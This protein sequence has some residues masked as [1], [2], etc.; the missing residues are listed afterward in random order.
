MM[1]SALINSSIQY[2][3][4]KLLNYSTP[5][6]ADTMCVK[7]LSAFFYCYLYIKLTYLIQMVPGLTY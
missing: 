7:L 2:N 6:N 1:F 5:N 3:L 4:I